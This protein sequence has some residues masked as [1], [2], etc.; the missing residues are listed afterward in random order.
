MTKRQK[1]WLNG[2]WEIT[3]ENLLLAIGLCFG[4]SDTFNVTNFTGLKHLFITIGMTT[5]LRTGMWLKQNPPPPLFDEDE[6]MANPA[7]TSPTPEEKKILDKSFPQSPLLIVGLSLTLLCMS[8]CAMSHLEALP[9]TATTQEKADAATADLED[10]MKD[11][12]NQANT[13][14]GLALAG[15]LALQYAVNDTNRGEIKDQMKAFSTLFTILAS[16]QD[17]TADQIDAAVKGFDSKIDSADVSQFTDE[18]NYAWGLA[19]SK[20]KVINDPSLTKTWLLLLAAS[21]NAA[22]K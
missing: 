20:L 8:G 4:E 10:W 7:A 6:P 1:H 17:L 14:K 13:Q 19:Y 21:A 18:I 22:A 3:T 12:N 2:L 9:P 5:A 11:P 15:K 16:G